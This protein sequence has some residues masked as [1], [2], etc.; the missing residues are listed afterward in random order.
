MS[1]K[2]KKKKLTHRNDTRTV[3]NLYLEE[4]AVSEEDKT[5]EQKKN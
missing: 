5:D 2:K 1:C 4:Q 3:E